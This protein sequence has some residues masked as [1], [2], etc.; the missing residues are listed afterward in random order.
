VFSFA[1]A[2]TVEY[3]ENSQNMDLLEGTLNIEQNQSTGGGGII[4]D[5]SALLAVGGPLGNY[6]GEGVKRTGPDQISIYVVRDGD[7]VGKIAELFDVTVNTIRWANGI[8]SKGTIH[9]GQELVILPISGIQHEVEKGDTLRSIVKEY[10][11]DLQEVLDFNIISL[12]DTLAVGDTL[13]IPNAIIGSH[14]HDHGS[15]SSSG[16]KTTRSTSERYILP[17]HGTVTQ[18]IHGRNGIDIGASYG[19]RVV[20][21]CTGRSVLAKTGYNGGYGTYA[22]IDCDDGVQMVYAHFSGLAIGP[23]ERVN[24]GQVVGYVGS[25]GR[26][27]GNHLHFEVRGA[28]Q[29]Y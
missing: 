26:S 17:L 8:N 21:A 12:D 18:G 20:S 13:T 11:A 1:S 23:G 22:V 6:E 7:N 2:D 5:D 15:A 25:T 3:G 16:T 4:I 27:T 10:D 28:A 19:T 9:P 24:Q 14:D 29:I